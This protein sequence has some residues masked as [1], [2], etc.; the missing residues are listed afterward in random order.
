MDRRANHRAMLGTEHGDFHAIL[1]M[2]REK[3]RERDIYIYTSSKLPSA[4]NWQRASTGVGSY[5]SVL[6]LSPIWSDLV[7]NVAFTPNSFQFIPFHL[8][9][10]LL[11]LL[12][13]NA[14]V[15]LCPEPASLSSSSSSSSSSSPEPPP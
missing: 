9:I 7:S 6:V 4:T 5:L 11:L 15:C 12:Q 8:G 14:I 1:D 2:E 3:E 13:P 10:S